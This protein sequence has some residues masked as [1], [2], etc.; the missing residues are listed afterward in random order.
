MEVVSGNDSLPSA[1]GRAADEPVMRKL[2]D[3]FRT[4]RG[5]RD[6]D[7]RKPRELWSASDWAR[8]RAPTRQR[9]TMLSNKARS[10]LE[11]LPQEVRPY[12]LCADHPR[13][14]NQLAACW[15]DVGLIEYLLEDMLI[16]RRGKRTGFAADVA[17]EIALLYE[18]H[19][20]RLRARDAGPSDWAP[21]TQA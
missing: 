6:R 4:R 9:D 8:V 16:D 17:Q 11:R 7:A 13:I 10:W 1:F 15:G 20:L 19:D 5:S 2:L 12:A 3:F 18:F 14:A 21:C